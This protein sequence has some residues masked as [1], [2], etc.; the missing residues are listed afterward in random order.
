MTTET[1]RLDRPT[2]IRMRILSYHI[3]V[4]VSL[5]TGRPGSTL[6]TVSGF[7]CHVRITDEGNYS[8]GGVICTSLSHAIDEYLEQLDKIATGLHSDKD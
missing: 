8:I 3:H 6:H 1:E 7:E 5:R 2:D 4:I